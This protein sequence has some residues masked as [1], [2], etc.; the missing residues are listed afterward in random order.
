MRVVLGGVLHGAEAEPRDEGERG[1]EHKDDVEHE[2]LVPFP[3]HFPQLRRA[4]RD[5]LV[6]IPLPC[7][8]TP[9]DVTHGHAVCRD[10]RRAEGGGDAERLPRLLLPLG[11]LHAKVVV[12]KLR[13]GRRVKGE[14][15]RAAVRGVRGGAVGERGGAVG[16]GGGGGGHRG[17][18]GARGGEQ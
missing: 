6:L 16:E 13:E 1:E 14:G 17:G 5:Q 9:A 18:R 2:L 8:V 4:L 7:E 15:E 11:P 12:R 10:E 3:V